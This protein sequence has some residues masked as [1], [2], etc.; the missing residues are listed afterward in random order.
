MARHEYVELP[1]GTWTQLTSGDISAISIYNNRREMWIKVQNGTGA[2]TG[3]PE[4]EA[5]IP[6]DSRYSGY[7]VN[8][9]LAD[10]APG[11]SSPN[12]VFGYSD[13]GGQVL[14]SHA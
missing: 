8:R 13:T 2:P 10:L 4:A 14:V 3:T 6:L 7:V 9:T 12:R 5:A 1:A 11:V